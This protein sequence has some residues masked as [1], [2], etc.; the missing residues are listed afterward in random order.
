MRKLRS[1]RERHL[2]LAGG[3]PKPETIMTVSVEERADQRKKK[4]NLFR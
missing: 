4:K 2:Q 1:K 3:K